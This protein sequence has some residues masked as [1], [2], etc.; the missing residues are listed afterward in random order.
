MQ[1]CIR[2][3]MSDHRVDQI[4]VDVTWK[5]RPHWVLVCVPSV[6]LIWIPLVVPTDTALSRRMA[7][8]LLSRQPQQEAPGDA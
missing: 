7:R 2:A 3:T 5:R 6:T 8:S 4:L 1:K